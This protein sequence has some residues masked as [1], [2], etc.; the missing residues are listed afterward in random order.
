[1]SDEPDHIEEGL[2]EYL[3]AL[4]S[5]P[6]EE[7]LLGADYRA[8]RLLQKL[9]SVEKQI[10]RNASIAR[11]ERQ[12]ITDWETRVN[13]PLQN[14]A[15]NLRSMLEGHARE[16]RVLHGRKTINL[17]YG[18]LSTTKKQDHWSV[19]TPGEYIEW[20]RGKSGNLV[21]V[22]ETPNLSFL[23]NYAVVDGNGNAIDV[24]TGEVIPGVTV[25]AGTDFTVSIKPNKE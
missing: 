2:D 18:T 9:A 20:A 15:V 11:L 3:L 5:D 4:E 21:R 25:T 14:S 8:N 22:T 10:E 6:E 1:M 19:M 12:K 16:Q 13:S 17:P 23:K 7:E 24:N